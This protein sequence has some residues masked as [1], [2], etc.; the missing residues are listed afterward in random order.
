MASIVFYVTIHTHKKEK[1][2]KKR[3]IANINANVKREGILSYEENEFG[4]TCTNQFHLRRASIV[5]L[6][7]KVKENDDEQLS[8]VLPVIQKRLSHATQA[9]TECLNLKD[10][11]QVW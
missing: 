9:L 5:V 10:T 11:V 3:I 4:I 6:C 1:K 2:K 8:R 7:R